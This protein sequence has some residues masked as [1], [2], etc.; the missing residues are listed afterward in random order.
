[1]IIIFCYRKIEG[2]RKHIV[3]RTTPGYRPSPMVANDCSSTSPI[4]LFRYCRA[5]SAR[6]KDQGKSSYCWSRKNPHRT[7]YRRNRQSFRRLWYMYFS[8]HWLSSTRCEILTQ[9]CA[10]F[11]SRAVPSR[12]ILWGHLIEARVI[13]VH[14][15]RSRKGCQNL[16]YWGRRSVAFGVTQRLWSS[17]WIRTKH[18][19][20]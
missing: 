3:R 4:T 9:D 14:A 1:M 12:C 10:F 8:F 20:C 15:S 7:T 5:F 17:R 6:D 13:L 2:V 16:R 18:F 19:L 11:Y